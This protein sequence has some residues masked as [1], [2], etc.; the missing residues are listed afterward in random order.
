MGCFRCT[1][2]GHYL[3]AFV[4][5]LRVRLWCSQTGEVCVLLQIISH[6]DNRKCGWWSGVM[7]CS[8]IS[9]L[10]VLIWYTWHTFEQVHLSKEGV[11]GSRK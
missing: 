5:C 9:Q 11:G 8:Q 3:L 6:N 10:K 1:A 4:E 2:Q 7:T